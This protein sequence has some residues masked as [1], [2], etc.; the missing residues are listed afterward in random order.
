MSTSAASTGRPPLA[1]STAQAGD[2]VVV[3]SSVPSDS[4]G[5]Y[6]NVG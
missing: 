4:T 3:P 2:T 1:P 5:R 6:G